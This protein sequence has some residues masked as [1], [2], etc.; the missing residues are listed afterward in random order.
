MEYELVIDHPLLIVAAEKAIRSRVAQLA[1]AVVGSPVH[2]GHDLPEDRP[3]DGPDDVR[4]PLP[5]G[6]G[7]MIDAVGFRI[8]RFATPIVRTLIGVSG[9][10]DVAVGG[11]ERAVMVVILL[12]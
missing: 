3:T 6:G 1:F 2:V 10:A 5:A 11:P 12:R 7:T 4:D 8:A 9:R